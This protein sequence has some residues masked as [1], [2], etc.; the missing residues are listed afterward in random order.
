MHIPS[1]DC[2]GGSDL[3]HTLFAQFCFKIMFH[4]HTH[5]FMQTTNSYVR[6]NCVEYRNS[7]HEHMARGSRKN[8]IAYL[9]A[10]FR[11]SELRS[12]KGA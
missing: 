7:R 4:V 3:N 10:H 2:G 5:L 1:M 9:P 12:G 6:R 11:R 8:M